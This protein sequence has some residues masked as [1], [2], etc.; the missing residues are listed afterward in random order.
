MSNQLLTKKD[1]SFDN[2]NFW[3]YY[4]LPFRGGDDQKELNLYDAIRDVVEIKKYVPTFK[5]WY[6]EFC[7][8][9]KADRDGLFENPKV[10]AATL[11]EDIRFAIEFH[12]WETTFVTI[13]PQK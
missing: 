8:K 7:P 12:L 4:I 1:I 6:N 10:I 5:E 3:H 2:L 9:E 11:T 13:Q